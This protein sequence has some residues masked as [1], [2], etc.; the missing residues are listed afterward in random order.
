MHVGLDDLRITDEGRIAFVLKLAAKLRGEAHVEQW[1]RGVKLLGT[2]AVGDAVIAATIDCDV[3][4]HFEPGKLAGDVL[5]DPH[6][7]A[8][9]L[10]LEDLD[11]H[12]LSRLGGKVAHELGDSFTPMVA[13]QLKRREGRLVEK[14]NASIAK[15]RDRLRLPCRLHSSPAALGQRSMRCC[16]LLRF[17]RTGTARGFTTGQV[18][19]PPKRNLADVAARR[20]TIGRRQDVSDLTTGPVF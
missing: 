20:I 9:H 19:S 18:P 12:R 14:A 5:L 10:E 4:I 1:E 13:R 6:V 7:A 16:P 2:S 15:Q 8:I 17:D 3:G 11:V